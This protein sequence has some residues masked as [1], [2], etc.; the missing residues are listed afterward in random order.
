MN[1][2]VEKKIKLLSKLYVL[3][4][5]NSLYLQNDPRNYIFIIIPWH[6]ATYFCYLLLPKLL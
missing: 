3:I 2:Y 6:V 5:K 1:D 4:L